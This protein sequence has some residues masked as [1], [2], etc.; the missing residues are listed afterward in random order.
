MFWEEQQKYINTSKKGI[1]YHPAII[2]KCL[3]LLAKSPAAYDELRYDEQKGTGFLILPS[4]RRLRDYKNYIRPERGFNP[5]I[6]KELMEKVKDFSEVE[7][8]VVLCFDEMKVEENLV[9][10]KHTGELIGFVDLGDP[11]LHDATGI[12]EDIA[13]HILV[14]LV[15]GVVNPI[16]YSFANF[17]TKGATASQLFPLFWKAVSIL[18]LTVQLKVIASTADGASSNRTFFRMHKHMD[19]HDER[20]DAVYRVENL[21]SNEKRYIFF[22]SDPPHLVKTA[23]NCL[24]NSGS[25]RETRYMWKDGQ[26]LLWSHIT[27]LYHEDQD[28]GLKLLP[29][30]KSEH[31]YLTPFSVMTVSLAAQVLSNTVSSVLSAYGPADAQETAKFC[32]MMDKFFDCVNGRYPKEHIE[33]LKPMLA[34]YTNVNDERLQWLVGDFL[35]Y[36]EDWKTSIRTR[37]GNYTANARANMFISWQTHEGLKITCNAITQAIK[38]LLEKGVGYVLP[39]CFCQDPLENYYGTQRSLGR[40][41]DNPTV[42]MV[43]YND[44][45]IRNMK[46]FPPI[47]GNVRADANREIDTTPLPRRITK[48]KRDDS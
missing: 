44:N 18:E 12:K 19:G 26:F 2:K 29:K 39:E 13:T 45:A 41:K 5:L 48:R 8:F 36:F 30:L 31:I 6:V 14:F 25:G 32:S 20:S 28:C 33:K 16:K 24:S 37:P 7:R 9:W 47:A 46:H 38:Y 15:R 17:A 43:G 40:R 27:Q 22:I 21:F 23:R 3:S 34:P 1:C 42:Q 10:D 11:D 35:T 4:K